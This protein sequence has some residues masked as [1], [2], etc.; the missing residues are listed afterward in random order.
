MKFSNLKHQ[1]GA[2]LAFSLVMLLLLTL[3]GT[4]MIQQNKQQL[5]MA[6]NT[7]LMTQAFADAEGVLEEAKSYV[8]SDSSHKDPTA[9]EEQKIEID[10][11]NHQCTPIQHKDQ[12]GKVDSS[13]Q[14][15]LLA[16]KTLIDERLP[17]GSPSKFAEIVQTWCADKN[18]IPTKECTSYDY[19]TKVVTC[20]TSEVGE[21]CTTK[22]SEGVATVANLF[23]ASDACYQHYDPMCEDDTYPGDL[24]S[25][26]PPKCPIEVY[27]IRAVFTNSDGATRE[28]ISAKQ[29]KC[30]T[31]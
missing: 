23:S 30:G 27:A 16:G 9:S 10:N 2:I 26:K 17:D 21:D 3:A 15:L 19:K 5:Q 14:Q 1:R 12:E 31:P 22:A 13:R 20:Y 11:D 28:I 8:L 7:R 25:P 6:G 24:C 4:R 29:V 18:G